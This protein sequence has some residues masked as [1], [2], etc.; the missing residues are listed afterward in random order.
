[1]WYNYLCHPCTFVSAGMVHSCVVPG[2][3]SRSNKAEC[4]GIKF[5]NLPTTKKILQVWLLL[6]GRRLVEVNV[7]SRICSKH[8]IGGQKTKDSLP[9]IFSWQKCPANTECPSTSTHSSPRL[10][11]SDIVNHD[12]SYCLPQVLSTHLTPLTD[13][14]ISLSSSTVNVETQ[15]SA[16]YFCIEQIADNDAAIH[17]YSGFNDYSTLIICFEFLGKSVD[18]LKYWGSKSKVPSMEK[19][20]TSRS[21]TPLNEYFLVLCRLRC[22]LLEMDLSFRFQISQSTVSRIIITWINFLFFKFKDIPIWPCRQQVNHFM[23]Q[24]FKE[25]YPTTRCIIDATELFIQSPSNPQA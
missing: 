22:G 3:N 12:H 24:L 1:M 17:F 11:S 15:T 5:Y 21:L 6:I 25:F 10:S 8:F 20:G 14:S 16:S 23:P 9:Q 4:K 2:C 13:H 19:R 18:H 7:H